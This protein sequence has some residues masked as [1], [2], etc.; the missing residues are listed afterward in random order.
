MRPT[1]YTFPEGD[2]E[3]FG[4]DDHNN[5]TAYTQVDK[6]GACQVNVAG[7]HRIQTRATYDQTW[8]KP[9][10][11]TSPNSNVT[12]FVYNASGNEES[13]YYIRRRDLPTLIRH[14]RHPYTFAYDGAGKPTSVSVPFTSGQNIVNV[15]TYD[16]S[17]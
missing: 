11:I 1:T 8:N 2:C 13:L 3:G 15:N 12:H 9:L 10:T 5:T 4:Y 14:T 17:E 16:A 7:N 6:T